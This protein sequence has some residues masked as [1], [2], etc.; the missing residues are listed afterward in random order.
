MLFVCCGQGDAIVEMLRIYDEGRVSKRPFPV[1]QGYQQLERSNLIY[2]PSFD[3][4]QL[5]NRG[6]GGHNLGTGKNTSERL[7]KA[8]FRGK[9][10]STFFDFSEYGDGEDFADSTISPAI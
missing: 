9:F 1:A 5:G 7:N 3:Y 8:G 2:Q 10:Q 4:S 6:Q